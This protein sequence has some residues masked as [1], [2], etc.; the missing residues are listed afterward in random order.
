MPGSYKRKDHFYKRAKEEGHRSRSAYKL[1]ELQK[2]FGLIKPK[3]YVL[4]LGCWPG[5][6]LQ[7]ALKTVGNE[8][9]VVGIDLVETED[10]TD[11][12]LKVICGDVAD[13]NSVQQAIDAAGREFDVVLSDMS[14]KLSGI[15]EA[16]RA[17]AQHCAE[18]ALWVADQSLREGG[19]LVIKAFKSSE[20]D[21]FVKS[22]RARFNKLVRAELKSTRKTSNEFFIVGLGFSKERE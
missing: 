4:D 10:I 13:E 19:N 21:Q 2:R 3:N 15:K 5:G 16:D 7:V 12:R 20:A 22:V 14:P 9:R 1:L 8:G 18:L 11:S 6:W 17:R